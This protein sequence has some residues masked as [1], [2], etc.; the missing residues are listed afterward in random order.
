MLALP[1]FIFSIAAILTTAGLSD[2][3]IGQTSHVKPGF[4]TTQTDHNNNNN[5]MV[6]SL[7]LKSP[8]GHSDMTLTGNNNG[9]NSDVSVTYLHDFPGKKTEADAL[10]FTRTHPWVRDDSE[11]SYDDPGSWGGMCK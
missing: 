7:S 4:H 9:Q 10:M 3:I 5:N 11:W 2:S 6:W 8:Q 1:A